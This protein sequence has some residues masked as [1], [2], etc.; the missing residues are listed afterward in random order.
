MS[1]IK[2]VK[3]C[4]RCGKELSRRNTNG[5]CT[6]L[7]KSI[8]NGT[9]TLY[10]CEMCGNECSDKTSHYNKKKHHFCS[11]ECKS[12]WQSKYLKGENNPN[13]TSIKGK[14]SR[15]GK[16]IEYYKCKSKHKLHF[17]SNECRL[18]YYKENNS[19][20]IKC[21]VCGKYINV[22]LNQYNRYKH[23]Y[24]SVECKDKGQA[25]ILKGENS[26][27][28]S[29]QKIKC[30]YCGK[31]ILINP[32][33]INL[34]EHTYCSQ[35]CRYK[36]WS[37]FY[38]GENNPKYD[39][40][41]SIEERQTKRQYL[42][43][44]EFIKKVLARDNYTCQ[45]CG[46][47]NNHMNVHHLDGYN[48]CKEKRTDIDNGVTLCEECHKNFHN[49]YGR[50]NNTSEQYEQWIITKAYEIWKGIKETKIA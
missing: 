19:I 49:I 8:Y 45:C 13:Y 39:K 22:P 11:I 30:S 20:K 31:E 37:K 10:K 21:E 17:C 15:C 4:K 36:G 40:S 26:P 9:R 34:N 50:G 42:E 12:E 7:C 16:E 44:D 28:Y 25:E 47:H 29:R 41:I 32:C 1:K 33:R 23:H 35:D 38:S 48:W 18:N 5:F 14:C 3:Y 27:L 2:E 43:Y 46:E 24:C 6:P